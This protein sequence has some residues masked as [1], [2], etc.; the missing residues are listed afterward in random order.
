MKLNPLWA[1]RGLRASVVASLVLASAAFVSPAQADEV[2]TCDDQVATIVSSDRVIYGTS[3]VDVIVVQGEGR[4]RVLAY[5]GA[6]VICGSDSKD[7][8]NGGAGPDTIYGEGNND[9]LIGGTGRDT[10]MAGPGDDQVNGGPARDAING[11]EGS[12]T[13]DSGIGLNYC[14]GDLLDVVTGECVIDE[15]APTI[16]D[17]SFPEIVEAG[18]TAIFSWKSDDSSGISYTGAYVGSIYGW[19]GDWCDGFT[20]QGVLVEGDSRSGTYQVECVI[21]A[22]AVNG[23]YTLFLASNDLVGNTTWGPS[24]NEFELVSGIADNAYPNLV[25]LTSPE[26]VSAGELITLDFELTDESGVSSAY[27]YIARSD[28]FIVDI[29]T[30]LLWAEAIDWYEAPISG[31]SFNGVWQLTYRMMDYAPA[32]TY[33]IWYGFSDIY[34]NRT[35]NTQGPTFEYLG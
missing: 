10:I 30:G 15:T 3:G 33:T 20:S 12:D 28:G 1:K 14:A 17:V 34:G 29:T 7:R 25:S 22:T 8:I 6:D 4:H 31:D 18:S 26:T 5:Q 11:Q 23:T 19:V 21:P 2:E 35:F 32:G 27:A 9:F 24:N 13:I 16:Y